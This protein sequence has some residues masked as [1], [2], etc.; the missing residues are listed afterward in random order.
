SALRQS[1]MSDVT[2]CHGLGGAIELMLLAY[3]ITGLHDHQRAA[4]R[5]GDLCLSIYRANANRW[6]VGVRRG[7]TEPG[8]FLGLAGIGVTMM[9][10]HDPGLV[11]SPVLPGRFAMPPRAAQH[12]EST[13]RQDTN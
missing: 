10:L 12:S 7:E 13:S 9:R 1:Q 2:L 8:L 5:A 4:R 3:E 11:G 6:T